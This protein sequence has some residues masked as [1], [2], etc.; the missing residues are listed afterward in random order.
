MKRLILLV[1]AAV[2]VAAPALAFH[3]GGVAHCNG[4]HTMHNSEDGAAMNYNATGTGPGTNPGFGWTDL[5]LY[6]N[7]SD[8]CL[9]CHG[10]NTRSYNVFESDPLGLALREYYSAGNFVF[11]LEDNINDGHA[12]SVAS[13][14]IPGQGSGHNIQSGIKGS[15]W[16]TTLTAPPSDGTSPLTNNR[17]HCSS[18]HDPHGTGTFRLLYQTGQDVDVGGETVIY[19]DTVV[20]YGISYGDVE[21]NDNHNAYVSGYSGWCN[22]CHTEFHQRSGRMIHPSGESLSDGTDVQYNRYRGTTDCVLSGVSPC[23]TGGAATAYLGDVPFED[24]SHTAASI[25]STLGPTSSSRVAC[26][27]CHRAHA[28]SAPNAGRWDFDVTFLW[29]DGHESG[30]WPIPFIPYDP[31]DVDNQRSL[32]NKCHG[33]DEFDVLP[34]P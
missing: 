27:S 5:L 28:T 20:A 23:G 19:G 32:C 9:E 24:D 31:R 16:D 21:T 7:A 25:T 3:D 2:I 33:Q 22:S 4:C 34:T 8:V 29:E 6:P 15:M 14:W 1:A 12:G 26:M 10:N 17:I 11:L 30:S 18:C 13:N